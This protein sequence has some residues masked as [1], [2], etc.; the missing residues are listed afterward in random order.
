MKLRWLLFT[1]LLTSGQAAGWA[2]TAVGESIGVQHQRVVFWNVENAFWPADD[3][4]RDDDEF[5]PQGAR[6]WTRGR[7][8]EKLLHLSRTILAA[9]D[10][11]IPPMLVGLAEVEGDSVMAYWTRSTPLRDMRYRYVVTDGPDQRGI[12]TALLYQPV[13]FRLISSEGH[14][15]EVVAD[16]HPT[17]DV[18]HAAGRLTNGD[19][20]DVVV[21]HL[22]SRL[23]GARASQ[24]MRDAAH[25]TIRQLTDS[26]VAERAT[27]RIII[28]GDMNDTP[29]AQR[30]WWGQEVENL[31]VPLQEALRR[32]PSQWG[33]HKYQG[34]WTFLDQMIVS[35][36]LLDTTST[37]R[38]ENA[39]SFSM[40]FMMTDD[41]SHLGKRPA[42]SYNGY[43]YEGGYSDHLPILLDLDVY[44]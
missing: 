32:H 30:R 9:G 7:L 36:A 8:R 40:P 42:R 6:H 41:V 43:A 19:T 4:Q 29:D 26:L 28:M 22:P 20:L 3:P 27:A 23:G 13:D 24:P 35:R 21:C 10:N 2:Q 25:R 1:V 34:R 31:M 37:V 17:R 33:S 39:R 16:A 5:T 15:V 11:G 44:F 14:R 12:Q 18:L 38:V